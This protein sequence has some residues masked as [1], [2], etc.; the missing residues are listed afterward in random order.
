M[1]RL[2]VIGLGSMGKNH[3]RVCSQLDNVDLVG[4]FDI[5]KDVSDLIAK[6]FNTESFMN[7]RDALNKIDGV[8]IATPT[9]DHFNIAMDFLD[10][11]KHVLIE[12]PICSTVKD[13]EKLVDKASELD[14]ML[15]VGHIERHN[16]VIK[17]IKDSLDKNHF[18]DIISINSKRAS[19]YPGRIRD[20]G[21]IFDFGVHDIDVMRYLAGEVVNVYSQAGRYNKKIE[22]EDHANISLNFKNG[23]FGIV[24]VN[25]L[26]PVKIR[27]LQMTCSKNFVEL[28]YINQ[29][30]DV[31]SS[32]FKNVDENNLYNTAIQYNRNHFSLQKS[33]PLKNEII[34]FVSSIENKRSPLVSGFDGLQAIKIAEAAVKSYKLGKVMKII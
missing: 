1:I 10:S 14:L 15:S 9:V 18:G 3:A 21:V 34:D 32:S 6:K 11:G 2:A 13:A 24:E 4:V 19:N 16:P 7:Y 17:F 8:I 26:T 23:I 33:E 27:K 12:K 31:S 28:D 30:V 25:W 5:K 29:S 22:F 20:V